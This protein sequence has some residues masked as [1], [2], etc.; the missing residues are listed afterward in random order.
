MPLAV[1]AKKAE[2]WKP[3]FVAYERF[4]AEQ[5]YAL[6]HVEHSFAEIGRAHV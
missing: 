6:L 3:A 4:L 2:P 1:A 5:G